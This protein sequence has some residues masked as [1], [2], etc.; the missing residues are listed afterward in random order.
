MMR[1]KPPF[2]A[3]VVGS[4]SAHCAAERGP[5]QA[6]QG[7]DHTGAAQG[8]RGPRDREDHQEAGGR[9]APSHDRRRIPPL[10]VAFRLLWPARRHG[11]VHTRPRHPVP[12]RAE[13]DGK[14]PRH[15]QARLHQSSDA[16]A[17]QVS[18]SPHQGDAENVHPEPGD[19][20]FPPRARR[21]RHQGIRRPRCH[22]RGPR[23]D[24][25]AGRARVLR[26]RLPLSAV[27][28]HRLGLS[29]LAGR[30]EKGARPRAQRR[31]TAAGLCARHQ[32]ARSKASRPTW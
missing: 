1:T 6:R 13:P 4:H 8:G 3:D 11:A 31:P 14:H 24:L 5:R 20:A 30:A 26:R 29:V 22:L 27:R 32:C 12:R 10:V 19:A 15:G 9:R 23:Q 18:Q 21:G 28:R 25:S 17:F 16:G 2:R 7:R